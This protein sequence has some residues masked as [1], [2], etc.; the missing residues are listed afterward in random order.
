MYYSVY[1]CLVNEVFTFN[2]SPIAMKPLH[3]QYYS[4]GKSISVNEV[5]T[6]N[7]SPIA[8]PPSSPILC[9]L[10]QRGIHSTRYS[11]FLSDCLSPSTPTLL[12][13][14]SI[15]VNEVFTFNASPIAFPPSSPI[16]LP[17]KE[18]SVNEP[19]HFQPLDSFLQHQCSSILQINLSQQPIA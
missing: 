8:F 16:L 4:I 1:K 10:S 9:N 13:C 7:A 14:K 3:H 17:C 11:T 18:I 2:A 5:F 15:L 12:R 19:I 6:F